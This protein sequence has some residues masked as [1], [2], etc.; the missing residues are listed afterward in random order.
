MTKKGGQPMAI[1]LNKDAY[2]KRQGQTPPAAEETPPIREVF[3]TYNDTPCRNGDIAEDGE[4]YPVRE[5]YPK[6]PPQIKIRPEEETAVEKPA[7]NPP[8]APPKAKKRRKYVGIY[9]VFGIIIMAAGIAL[10]MSADN[11]APLNTGYSYAEY[12]NSAKNV[13]DV[14]VNADNIRLNVNYSN[15]SS[16]VTLVTESENFVT[17]KE[18]S[19]SISGKSVLNVNFEAAGTD[20]PDEDGRLNVSLTL[21]ADHSGTVQLNG[22]NVKLCCEDSGTNSDIS[23]ACNNGNIELINSVAD[24]V[25]LRSETGTITAADV[26]AGS[27]YVYSGSGGIYIQGTTVSGFTYL[28]AEDDYIDLLSSRF[29]GETEI[30]SLSYIYGRNITFEN[31]VRLNCWDS[32]ISLE[33]ADFRNMTVTSFNTDVSI[34]TPNSLSDYTVNTYLSDGAVCNTESGGSGKKYLSVKASGGDIE[35]DFD[36]TEKDIEDILSS[37]T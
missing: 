37:L 36:Y 32:Y 18:T 19:S 21:P 14:I 26:T 10:K 35:F 2:P 30:A 5:I 7:A 27:L 20:S 29:C 17:M 22:N 12:T 3:P 13:S 16:T 1:N 15:S 23:L 4:I 34:S 28:K 11:S 24:K 8:T 31:E 9:A 6:P 25:S 33:N